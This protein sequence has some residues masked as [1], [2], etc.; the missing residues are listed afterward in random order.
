MEEVMKKSKITKYISIG[1]KMDCLH[2][3]SCEYGPFD[4]DQRTYHILL[5]MDR[6]IWEEIPHFGL[7]P[8]VLNISKKIYAFGLIVD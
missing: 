5:N 8:R 2:L 1:R 4:L 7:L 3:R 6:P